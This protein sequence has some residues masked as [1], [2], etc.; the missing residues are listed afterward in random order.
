MGLWRQSACVLILV[1]PLLARY[2]WQGT[3]PLRSQHPLQ[4]CSEF[5]QVLRLAGECQVWE[6]QPHCDR[7]V[8]ISAAPMLCSGNGKLSPS[9]CE[10]KILS[11]KLNPNV[12]QQTL[13]PKYNFL[14]QL[15]AAVRKSPGEGPGVRCSSPIISRALLL[16]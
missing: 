6:S 3:D 2:L 1:L 16:D 4:G 14:L 10:R 9:A 13:G 11:P 15:I 5:M 8:G 7:P 12:E